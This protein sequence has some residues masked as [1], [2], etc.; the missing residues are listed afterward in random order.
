MVFSAM[1]G[2]QVNYAS[3]NQDA[4][5]QVNSILPLVF[6]HSKIIASRQIQQKTQVLNSRSQGFPVAPLLIQEPD[7]K[8]PA[9]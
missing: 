6:P 9:R 8:P 3:A 4:S 2:V 7:E 1:Q 5:A